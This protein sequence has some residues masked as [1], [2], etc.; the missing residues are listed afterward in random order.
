MNVTSPKVHEFMHGV[1]FLLIEVKYIFDRH[2]NVREAYLK[3]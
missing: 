2:G 1:K 3:N